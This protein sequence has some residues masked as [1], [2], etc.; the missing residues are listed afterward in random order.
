MPVYILTIQTGSLRR[1]ELRND[2]DRASSPN[3][4]LVV[5]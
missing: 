2:D 3:P 5:E 1:I 4:Q